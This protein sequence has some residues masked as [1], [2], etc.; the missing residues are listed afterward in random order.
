MAKYGVDSIAND[1]RRVVFKERTPISAQML[2]DF[3]AGRPV[4]GAIDVG[5]AIVESIERWPGYDDQSW[6]ERFG[7]LDR[8][9]QLM[10]AQSAKAIMALA[11]AAK[12]SRAAHDEAIAPLANTQGYIS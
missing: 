3:S 6:S 10:A 12:H 1:H 11:S 5:S 9:Y 4:A 8:R 7:E 2:S